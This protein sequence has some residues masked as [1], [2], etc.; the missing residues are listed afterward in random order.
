MNLQ[1]WD[2][3]SP[4]DIKTGKKKGSTSYNSQYFG[5]TIGVCTQCTEFHSEKNR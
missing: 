3:L 1:N 5:L 4:Q 2:V